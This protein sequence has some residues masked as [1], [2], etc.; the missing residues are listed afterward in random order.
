M[1]PHRRDPPFLGKYIINLKLYSR[2]KL[3]GWLLW[4]LGRLELTV[5]PGEFGLLCR[6]VY[7]KISKQGGMQVSKQVCI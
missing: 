5:S 7:S 6:H 4:D 2:W 3:S 1:A